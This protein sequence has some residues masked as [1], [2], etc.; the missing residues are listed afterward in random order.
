[1]SIKIILPSITQKIKIKSLLSREEAERILL[2]E[3]NEEIV[4]LIEKKRS[5]NLSEQ[6]YMKAKGWSG[7]VYPFISAYR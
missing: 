2:D 7:V 3:I 4:S 6:P 5:I 1:M